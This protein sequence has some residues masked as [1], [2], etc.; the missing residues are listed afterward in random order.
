MPGRLSPGTI[1]NYR[2]G[3]K[4]MKVKRVKE[5]L[6][7]KYC[8][9]Q[10]KQ[11]PSVRWKPHLLY[12]LFSPGAI[13]EFDGCFFL[14]TT[15]HPTTTYSRAKSSSKAGH[16]S[17]KSGYHWNITFW[18]TNQEISKRIQN[19]IENLAQSYPFQKVFC[20]RRQRKQIKQVNGNENHELRGRS[21][22]WLVKCWHVKRCATSSPA[23]GAN[24]V[25]SRSL[26][27]S[28][29]RLFHI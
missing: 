22:W 4:A 2:W 27:T 18:I 12:L 17:Q 5:R 7:G 21:T 14:S 11:K 20:P 10:N 24:W 8:A 1:S 13:K 23:Y 16:S 9:K 15:G 6:D 26:S 29:H 19:K 3:K 28:T 25:T